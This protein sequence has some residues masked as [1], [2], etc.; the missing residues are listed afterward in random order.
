M[1]IFVVTKEVLQKIKKDSAE[2]NQAVDFEY[3]NYA[4]NFH[5]PISSYGGE[6][7]SKLQ[8]V[9]RKYDLERLFQN[10]VPSSFKLFP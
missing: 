7:M 9:S 4:S 5:D 6:N 1:T 3:M 2:R 8:E 10:S